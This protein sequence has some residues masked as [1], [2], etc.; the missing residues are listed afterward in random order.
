MNKYFFTIDF[1]CAGG[2]YTNISYIINKYGIP[3]NICEVGSFEGST[4]F[5]MSD[6]ITPHNNNLQIYAIDPHD[7]SDDLNYDLQQVKQ[8]FEMNLK[9]NKH[10]NINYINKKSEDGLIDLI[11]EDIKFELIY[12]DGDHK[13]STV[14]TDLVL[15]WKILKIGGIILCDD[16]TTWKFID[17]NGTAS[18]QMSPRLAVETFIQCNWHKLNLIQIPDCTQTAFIKI[19]E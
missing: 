15:C 12:I 8:R 3:N 16:T 2:S 19:S 1:N 7:K 17:K 5:W 9:I 14:L 10:K 6:N 13:A 18:N 11:N 4:T